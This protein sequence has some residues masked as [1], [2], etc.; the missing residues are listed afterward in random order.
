LLEVA[1]SCLTG[2]GRAAGEVG[3]EEWAVGLLPS[4]LAVLPAMLA[5][6]AASTLAVAAVDAARRGAPRPVVVLDA[7]HV[8][9]AAR[10]ERY[11]RSSG[12][13]PGS[14]FAPMSRFWRT[15]DGF[16]RLHANYPWHRDR[17]LTVLGCREDLPSVAAALLCRGS[18]QVEE[19]FTRAGALA[20]AVRTAAEWNVHP[21]GRA[22]AGLPL[23]VRRDGPGPARSA[24][25]GEGRALQG[26]RVLDLTRVIAGPVATRTLA[27]WGADV[28]RVD[29]PRLPEIEAQ[30]IDTLPGKRST[31]LDAAFA[32]D[33]HRL[34]EL[35]AA[36]DVVVQ[37]YRP[38]AF[39]RLGLDAS[40]LEQRHPHLTVITLSAWGATG[41]WAQRRGFDSLVQ[42]PTG[43]AAAASPALGQPGTL[44]AQVLDHATGYLAAAAAAASVAATL[45][46]RPPQ[47]ADLSLGQAAHW[48]LT[49][50]ATSPNGDADPAGTATQDGADTWSVD[51][52][53]PA[54]GVRVIGPPGRIGQLT[55]TWHGTTRFGSDP[56][57]FSSHLVLRPDGAPGSG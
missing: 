49:E 37:G 16:V 33:R 52:P 17:A 14:L 39:A 7:R 10:S 30:C 31:L 4:A 6:T 55:P 24:S 57:A 22:V 15:R 40:S 25:W 18:H 45:A 19:E 35:L 43:I 54:G 41:P 46:G 1:W 56:P 51:V 36:A 47:H 23:V 32:P 27:A 42:A 2:E 29:S 26:L 34:E 3:V 44:P 8:A 38:G 21:Q 48:L 9:A 20:F 13:A 11:T 53:G 12:T 50:P 5:A 28:L